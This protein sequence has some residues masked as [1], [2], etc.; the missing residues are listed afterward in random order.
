MVDVR[1]RA[2]IK[3]SIRDYDSLYSNSFRLI[4]QAELFAKYVLKVEGDD[5]T[6]IEVA[7]CLNELD[8]TLKMRQE[9]DFLSPTAITEMKK[10][11]DDGY[12]SHEMAAI[13]NEFFGDF[14][15]FTY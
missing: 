4:Y 15:C 7:H 10:L 13:R 1:A 12:D 11:I 6:A 9:D 5:V 2:G 14:A 8:G 3:N